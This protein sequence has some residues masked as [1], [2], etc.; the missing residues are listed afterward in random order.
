MAIWLEAPGWPDTVQ[1]PC[2]DLLDYRKRPGTQLPPGLPSP[3]TDFE[4]LLGRRDRAAHR[5]LLKE[6]VARPGVFGFFLAA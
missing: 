4:L 6:L 5:L 3:F 2:W 1:Q